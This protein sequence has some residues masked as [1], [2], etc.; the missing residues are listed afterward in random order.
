LARTLF[1]RDFVDLM[2]MMIFPI[3]LE[4]GKLLFSKDTI[5]AAFKLT[6]SLV[7]PNGVIFTNYM[8][9]G[10]LKISIIEG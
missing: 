4:S 7:T 6:E 8:G 5:P 2:F 1:K 3:T 9:A 10:Q